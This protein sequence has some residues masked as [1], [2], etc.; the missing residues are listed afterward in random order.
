[1]RLV[2]AALEHLRTAKVFTKLDLLSAY[3]LVRFC[4]GNEWKTT[5]S[6]ATTRNWPHPNTIKELQRFLGFTNFYMRFI[7]SGITT[8]LTSLL[9]GAPK[10]LSWNVLRS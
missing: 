2:P 10:K 6:T 8:P 3:N 4:E 9:K 7:H 1:M 5:F